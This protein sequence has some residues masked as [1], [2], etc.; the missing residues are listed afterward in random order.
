MSD[1]ADSQ[2]VRALRRIEAEGGQVDP[3]AAV[4]CFNSAF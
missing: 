2:L 3:Q 4:A 1:D